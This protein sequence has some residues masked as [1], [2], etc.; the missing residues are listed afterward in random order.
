MACLRELY[1]LTFNLNLTPSDAPRKKVKGV[2]VLSLWAFYANLYILVLFD[3]ILG[4][5]DTL[6][7]GLYFNGGDRHPS[8]GY[9]FIAA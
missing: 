5:K 4:R 7:H 2:C 3:V 1:R 6:A 9:S 8:P